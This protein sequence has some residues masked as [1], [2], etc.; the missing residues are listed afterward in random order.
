MSLLGVETNSMA[1]IK[2]AVLT[3]L[4]NNGIWSVVT[5]MRNS[6]TMG[7]VIFSAWKP[8]RRTKESVS[9]ENVTAIN[10]KQILFIITRRHGSHGFYTFIRQEFGVGLEHAVAG[11]RGGGGGAAVDEDIVLGYVGLEILGGDNAILRIIAHNEEAEKKQQE[12]RHPGL[13]C[14][15]SSKANL[16]LP[17]EHRVPWQGTHK[18]RCIDYGEAYSLLDFA[19]KNILFRVERLSDKVLVLPFD[20]NEKW[21]LMKVFPDELLMLELELIL[22]YLPSFQCLFRHLQCLLLPVRRSSEGEPEFLPLDLATLSRW[23]P[24]LS[25]SNDHLP[26]RE[27]VRNSG[28]EGTDHPSDDP[29]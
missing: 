28:K 9:T 14:S 20:P 24:K 25:L 26:L 16:N 1:L 5:L 17:V 29:P 23:K 12:G 22:G 19:Q 4:K 21:R 13:I 10:S 11:E 27:V 2:A 7:A 8:W 6:L 18:T 15:V 3:G